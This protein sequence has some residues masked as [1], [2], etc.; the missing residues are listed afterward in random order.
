[1]SERK[2]F[3]NEEGGV[4]NYAADLQAEHFPNDD[5]VAYDSVIEAW[6]SL[7]ELLPGDLDDDGEYDQSYSQS[8]AEFMA[9]YYNSDSYIAYLNG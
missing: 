5:H 1:M 6:E 2:W 7:G 4:Y 3:I 8:G 9:D